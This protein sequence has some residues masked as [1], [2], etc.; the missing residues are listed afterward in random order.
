MNSKAILCLTLLLSS[1]LV[2]CSP[3][4]KVTLKVVDDNGQP[5]ADAKVGVGYYEHSQPASIDGLTDNNGIFEAS[6]HTRAII[7]EL[8]FSA[9]K[10]G[11]YKTSS[12]GVVLRNYDKYNDLSK[13]NI[14]QTIVLK[15]IIHPIPMYAKKVD[16]AHEQ[17]PAFDKPLGFDLAAGDWVAPYGQGKTTHMF[18]MWHVDQDTTDVS[19]IHGSRHRFGWESKMIISF[20]NPGDGIQEFDMPGLT[21]GSEMRSPQIAPTNGYLPKLFKHS[22]WHP[23]PEHA[24]SSD[25]NSYDIYDNLH[26]NYLLRVSTILDEQGNVKSA[27][28]GKI[29]GDFEE[30]VW[31]FLN[32]TT[33]SLELEFD[34]KQN[35]GRGGNSGWPIY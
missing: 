1:M 17:P 18:F 24:I 20:P 13:W 11:Y 28:Y 30:V 22:G 19:A 16:I 34:P 33:N 6:H 14:T 4:W 3:K 31:M 35:L 2:G 7:A 25:T 9:E 32:P 8:G 29:Y 12:P 15:K 23:V 5:V 10:A 27:Q 26:K 21:E